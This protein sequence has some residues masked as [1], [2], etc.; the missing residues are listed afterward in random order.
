MRGEET[1]MKEDEKDRSGL[2]EQ[3]SIDYKTMFF[4]PLSVVLVQL[5][6]NYPTLKKNG[7]H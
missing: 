3:C 1:R 5:P 2:L 6:L 7:Y 4:V